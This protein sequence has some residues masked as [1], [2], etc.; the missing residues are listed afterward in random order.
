MREDA[1]AERWDT[2]EISTR[3]LKTFL[4]YFEGVRGRAELEALWRTG[5][6]PLSLEYME[7]ATNYVSLSFLERFLDT[8]TDASGDP[9]FMEKAGRHVATPESLGFAYWILRGVGTPLLAYTKTVDLAKT[10]NR[11][12]QFVIER[13]STTELVLSYKSNRPERNR[14]A[15]RG[16]MANFAGMTT[17]WGL[18][19]ANVQEL[20]CQ[21]SGAAACRYHLKWSRPPPLAWRR[22]AVGGAGAAGG[23]ALAS[24]VSVGNPLVPCAVLALCGFFAGAWLDGRRL[25]RS[26]DELLA[27]Q[28]QGLSRSLE[29]LQRRADEVFRANVEL[30]QR[31]AD[32]TREL[33]EALER[34]QRLDQL[35]SEFFANVSHELRTPLTLILAPV[36]DRLGVAPSGPDRELFNGIR[37]NARRLLRFIDD[38]LDLSRI[39]AGQLRLDVVPFDATSLVQQV[40]GVFGGAAE[41]R[42]VKLKVDAPLTAG[43]V[44]G[45]LHRLE[46]VLSNLVGNA[47]KF[48]PA[49]GDITVAVKDAGSELR[50]AVTDTGPGIPP[51]ELERIFQRFYQL[52]DEHVQRRGGVGIGLALAKN[53]AELHGGRIEVASTVGVGS[54]FTLVLPKGRAHFAPDVV[55]RR[56]VQVDVKEGR[57]ATDVLPE[58]PALLPS[59]PEPVRTEHQPVTFDG[60]RARLLVVEDNAELRLLLK[61]LLAPVYDV[62]LAE[63]GEPGLA[64]ARKERPDLVLS[65]VMMP[66]MSGTSLCAAI[67]S[68]PA[69]RQTPVVLLTARSGPEAALEGFAAGADEFVE[70]PF[71]PRVLLARVQA[72]LRLKAMSL[73][74]ASSARLAAVGTL[75]AGVGH[76]VRNPVNAVLNGVRVLRARNAMDADGKVLLDVIADGAERIERISAALLGHASPGDRGGARPTDV[77]EGLEATLRLLA[78]RFEGT[79][80]HRDF[81]GEDRVVAAAAELNQVFLN[82][83]DNA[84][85]ASPKNLWVTVAERPKTVRVTVADD[86]PGIPPEVA[87]RIFDPFFTTREPGQGTG[88]GLYLSRQ[89]VQRW[90]GELTFAPRSGGGATFM[91]ELPKEAR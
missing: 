75:A 31:V 90:G 16:R 67:K 63:D 47:F 51:A 12:G 58:R 21:V 73:Q 41:A 69:L 70:K 66:G 36:E 40:V 50:I 28:T 76:E 20:E 6:L 86:G 33:K 55:E 61:E 87:P 39:D 81:G 27:E 54:T 60:R 34:L 38:L 78:H 89:S 17:V 62:L 52:A 11:V 2:P 49:G 35:K 53:L 59:A 8:L 68:D 22:F 10:Y 32:R 9:E 80:V 64:M 77:R 25:S 26:K 5:R 44:W 23:L 71:H 84:L 43:E 7:E 57:R 74:V 13:S 79:Q 56:Q 48:T 30:D 18:P 1:Q 91:V 29:E 15:C 72:Q 24:A 19:E 4:L 46:S 37:R 85:K 88:L 65:D 45:D 14:H 3:L 82:L 42:G 83:I